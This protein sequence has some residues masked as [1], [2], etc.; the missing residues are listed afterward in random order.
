[1]TVF[2]H[3][4]WMLINIRLLGRPPKL[5]ASRESLIHYAA[6]L[7]IQYSR[8]CVD[9]GTT[10]RRETVTVAVGIIGLLGLTQAAEPLPPQLLS[11]LDRH[12]RARSS[13]PFL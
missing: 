12:E 2:Q 13:N 8:I 6:V 11:L 1:M 7:E 5:P 4:L 9:Q 10:R 3:V